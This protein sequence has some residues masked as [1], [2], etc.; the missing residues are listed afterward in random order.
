MDLGAALNNLAN[1]INGGNTEN[2][3]AMGGANASGGAGSASQ[4]ERALET[5]I[6]EQLAG[7]GNEA[8]SAK[9]IE[10][11]ASAA[12]DDLMEKLGLS[13]G[14]E[15]EGGKTLLDTDKIDISGLDKDTLI[16]KLKKNPSSIDIDKLPEDLKEKLEEFIDEATF[17]DQE[18]KDFVAGEREINE[19]LQEAIKNNPDADPAEMEKEIREAYALENPAHAE[20]KAEV[21]AENEKHDAA[22]KEASDSFISENPVPE[23]G[24]FD[25]VDD[26]NKAMDEWQEN[27]ESHMSDFEKQ[28]VED[29]PKYEDTKKAEAKAE[30]LKQLDGNK[31]F[32]KK[33]DIIPDDPGIIWDGPEKP[34]MPYKPADPGIIWD[35]PSND[36]EPWKIIKEGDLPHFIDG[37]LEN[38]LENR[39]DKANIKY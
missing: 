39:I 25:S 37:E 32:F 8:E 38:M 12:I 19:R 9:T 28:Y 7:N 35:R 23:M 31:P 3:G 11:K 22:H 36:D 24:N 1:K 30:L 17:S 21:D 20:A 33:P 15:E 10:E 16:D 29:N 34:T 14:G 2:I 26:F 27:Y 6:G 13:G 18:S 4:L 5:A